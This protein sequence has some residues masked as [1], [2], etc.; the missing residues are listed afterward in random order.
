MFFLCTY[1]MVNLAAFVESFGANPS[2]RPRFRFHHWSASLLGFVLSVGA[3]LLVDPVAAVVAATS[4]AAVVAFLSR[5]EFASA[6]GDARRGFQYTMAVRLLQ[7]LRRRTSDPKNWRP[8]F[9]VMAGNSQRHLP[10]IWYAHWMAGGRGLV[11][12][13]QVISGDLQAFAARVES[14]RSAM[15]VFFRTHA[16]KAM[17]EVVFARDVDEG[18]RVL[19]QAHSIGP[20]KPNTVLYGWP[21][22]EGRAE[23]L[24]QHIRDTAA[25]G[26]SVVI[27]VDRG[28]PTSDRTY[29]RIDV[30]WRGQKNGSL[31]VTLAHLLTRNWEW[32]GST[33]RILRVVTDAAGRESS[34]EAV[35]KLVQAARITAEAE[36]VVSTSPFSEVVK[37]HSRYADVVF[38]GFQMHGDRSPQ[39]EYR[40]TQDLLEG[41]P[42]TILV[43]STGEA[44]LLA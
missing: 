44:D 12:A 17:P 2:F 26:K 35:R 43:H 3:M 23:A 16:L 37:A 14:L 33:L 1:G 42:T 13:A 4:I 31:M 19:V 29:R 24:H 36:V 28:L 30:W 38:L 25:L 34:R 7:G 21:R 27:V 9:L 39:E 10:L 8:T 6:F 5:R 40:H 32:R 22:T 20:L 41:L 18:I 11:T 15:D